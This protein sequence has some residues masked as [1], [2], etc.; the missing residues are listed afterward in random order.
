MPKRLLVI[1]GA[2]KGQSYLLPE[3]GAVLIGNSRKHTDICLHDLFVA[4]VHCQVEVDEDRITVSDRVTPNGILVNGTKVPQ[5]ELQLGDV[6]RVGNSYLRLE[7]VVAEPTAEAD[8]TGEAPAPAADE[9]GKLPNLPP[10]R[11]GELA[12]RT[13]AHYKIGAEIAPGHSGAVFRARDL[14]TD[15]AV[16]LKVLSP[17][18]PADPE[19]MQ[20][21]IRA[22]KAWLP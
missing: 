21:F 8:A 17:V 22:M 14:K 16:A 13:L 5:R 3:A 20:R 4:R 19:E 12:G 18:F 9:P 10:H 2:D 7:D 15:E 11:L 6:I 1:D